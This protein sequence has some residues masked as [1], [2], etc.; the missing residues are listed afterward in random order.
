MGGGAGWGDLFRIGE[1]EAM[2][3]NWMGKGSV[4]GSEGSLKRCGPRVGRT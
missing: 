4:V 3:G 1:G 2:E